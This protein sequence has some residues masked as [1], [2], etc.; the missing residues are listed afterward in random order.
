MSQPQPLPDTVLDIVIDEIDDL[1][2]IAVFCAGFEDSAW[3]SNALSGDLVQWAADWILP[4]EELA[5][6][7]HATGVILLGKALSRVYETLDYKNRGE[8]GEMLLHIIL[9]TFYSSSKLIS[10][11]YFKDAANDTVKGFDCAHIVSTPDGDLELWLGESKLYA[12]SYAAAT[13]LQGEL[14]KHLERDYLRY[15][16]AAIADKVPADHPHRDEVLELL[17]RR[18]SLDTTFAKVVIP[19]FI[20]YDSDAADRHKESTAEYLADLRTE[21]L[22]H[23]A[24]LRSRYEGWALPRKIR[25]HVFFLPMNR[26]PDLT[27][28]FDERLK[29]WQAI[30]NL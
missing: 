1:L 27:A 7:N 21:V 10:R 8:I 18:T 4:E 15:E 5:G 25:A 26:K 11:I 12:D 22:G 30:T 28:A 24:S 20:S 16:F 19:I 9:R 2:P 6:Y 17:A 23:W 13:A 29:A 3:R 14:Q